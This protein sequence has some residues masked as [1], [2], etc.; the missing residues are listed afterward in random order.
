MAR[1]KTDAARRF[2]RHRRVRNRV[3]GTLERPRLVVRRSAK[4]MRAQLIDDHAGRTLCGA[5]T[6]EA[7]FSKQLETGGNV[8]AAELLGTIVAQRAQALGI[9]RMVFDR[10]GY[11]YHGR[12]RALADAVRTTGMEL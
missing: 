9:R 4:H 11:R 7:E 6:L 1:Y 10:A 8:A 2:R 3:S 5:S 12:V